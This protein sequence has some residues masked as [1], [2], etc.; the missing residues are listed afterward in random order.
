M[1]KDWAKAFYRSGPWQA[2]RG[3]ALRRDHFTCQRCGARAE[4]VHHK[5]EL[6][7]DNIHN[8]NVA[9]NIDKLECICH[10]CHTKE[11]IGNDG[12]VRDGM[13]FDE[14]GNVVQML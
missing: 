7:L 11:T 12:D 3:I 13:I 14:D 5:I 2:A 1:A 10:I 9:L 6:T 4:E 8:I